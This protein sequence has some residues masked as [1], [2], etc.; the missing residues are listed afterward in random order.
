MVTRTGVGRVGADG[1]VMRALVTADSPCNRCFGTE[2][3]PTVNN[4]LPVATPLGNGVSELRN[5]GAPSGRAGPPALDASRVEV[6]ALVND[7]NRRLPA[8]TLDMLYSTRTPPLLSCGQRGSGLRRL[9]QC[10]GRFDRLAELQ[11]FTLKAGGSPLRAR[12]MSGELAS[13]QKYGAEASGHRP[14]RHSP[15]PPSCS[16]RL[17]LSR[18]SQENL[19]GR[20]AGLQVN[21]LY[22]LR[23]LRQREDSVDWCAATDQ[24]QPPACAPG[25]DARVD[26]DVHTA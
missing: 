2:V 4:Y 26:D 12:L 7:Q 1:R 3:Q 11:A 19:N 14:A 17:L 9:L 22:E 24:D 18:E 25:T 21:D 5:G 20:L 15:A 10:D 6:N 23:G 16:R 13:G 8:I